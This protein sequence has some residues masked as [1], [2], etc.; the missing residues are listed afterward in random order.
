MCVFI[1]MV[2][3]VTVDWYSGRYCCYV[4]VLLSMNDES[5]GFLLICYSLRLNSHTPIE[6]IQAYIHLLLFEVLS[7]S[8]AFFLCC[9][10][11][12]VWV[13]ACRF[14]SLLFDT[15]IQSMWLMP[16][17]L[18]LLFRLLLV[19]LPGFC[20]GKFHHQH[21]HDHLSVVQ[22]CKKDEGWCWLVF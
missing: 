12:G 3:S 4:I 18:L 1:L 2:R 5:F 10:C 15:S 11:I 19:M 7:Y 13:V 20:F 17:L 8:S 6:G 14:Q 9:V 21:H 22:Q 16:M